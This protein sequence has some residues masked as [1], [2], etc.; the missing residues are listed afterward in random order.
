MSA[1]S[2]L[3]LEE[4]NKRERDIR[5]QLTPLPSEEVTGYITMPI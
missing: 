1:G 4:Y 5:S 2:V 3:H